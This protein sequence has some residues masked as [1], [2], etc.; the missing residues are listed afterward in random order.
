MNRDPVLDQID[1]KIDEL[2]EL[3]GELHLRNDKRKQLSKIL[4]SFFEQLEDELDMMS[5]DWEA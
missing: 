4:F 1:Q 5:A 3:L 2:D